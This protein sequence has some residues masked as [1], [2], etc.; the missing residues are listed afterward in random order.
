M[1]LWG[2]VTVAYTG[3]NDL[4]TLTGLRVLL[5]IL[6]AGEFFLS[7]VEAILSYQTGGS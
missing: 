4:N 6:E 5:G 7:L 2:S 3:I 1:F